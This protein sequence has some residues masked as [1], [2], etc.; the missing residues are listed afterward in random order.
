MTTRRHPEYT[1]HKWAAEAKARGLAVD[2]YKL[3]EEMTG[4]VLVAQLDP[5]VV[6]AAVE[7]RSGMRRLRNL[8]L[9]DEEFADDAVPLDGPIAFRSFPATGVEM[10]GIEVPLGETVELKGDD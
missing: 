7:A 2:A 8:L 1:R 9:P 4:W 5:V 6:A 3:V 10:E